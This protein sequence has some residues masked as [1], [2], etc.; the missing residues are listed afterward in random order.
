MGSYWFPYLFLMA[1]LLTGAIWILRISRQGKYGTPAE[2]WIKY[3]T[4]LG[5]VNLV[6]WMIVW[7][8]PGAQWIG[9]FIIAGAI[10]EWWKIIRDQRNIGIPTLIFVLLLLGF[11][12]FLY[13]DRNV[14]LYAYFVVVLFDG[15]SQVSG[16]LLGKRPLLPRISPRK[17]V[18]GL[19]GGILI[20]L[21]TSLLTYRAF[22]FSLTRMGWITLFT[23]TFAF[24]G[25]LLG[26]LMKR[27]VG[28]DSYSRV[29]PGHGGILDRFDSWI[30][31]GAFC[32]LLSCIIE[33]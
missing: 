19:A 17:T 3:V 27:R 10:A 9:F 20:T 16:Q 15:S 28:I 33:I 30:S 2:Q 1:H 11:W 21:V 31:A 14:I 18:E 25:D 13:L 24:A 26:S 6:W 7:F 5:V 32:Y 29:L 23:M 22:S 12:K 8:E 4:Y